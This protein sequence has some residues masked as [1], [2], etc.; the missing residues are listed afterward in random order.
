MF[1]QVLLGCPLGNPE[2]PQKFP[3]WQKK[4][5]KHLEIRSHLPTLPLILGNLP[6]SLCNRGQKDTALPIPSYHANTMHLIRQREQKRKG[7]PKLPNSSLVCALVLLRT[8]W[9]GLQPK[10]WPDWG[11]D[12]LSGGGLKCY[13]LQRLGERQ[14]WEIG[15]ERM[16][17]GYRSPEIPREA[18]AQTR[19]IMGLV[20][21]GG[22][23]G[24]VATTFRS[25]GSERNGI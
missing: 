20:F 3:G 12:Q 24:F 2:F 7:A 23:P 6:H 14:A 1:S 13:L 5:K 15:L 22:R 16:K 21:S 18:K 17:A 8:G 9:Q 25:G 11:W 19:K 4:K 10:D